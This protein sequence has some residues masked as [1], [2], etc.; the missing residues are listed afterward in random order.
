MS[1]KI[2]STK[3]P[4]KAEEEATKADVKVE[5]KSEVKEGGKK[6]KKETIEEV[7]DDETS[8]VTT[9][10]PAAKKTAVASDEATET[11]PKKKSNPKKESAESKPSKKGQKQQIQDLVCNFINNLPDLLKQFE[12][13][14]QEIRSICDKTKNKKFS[15][16]K[17]EKIP[18]KRQC[19]SALHP[20]IKKYAKEYGL[21][22]ET[23]YDSFAIVGKIKKYICNPEDKHYII[24]SGAAGNKTS[25]ILNSEVDI[26]GSPVLK[27]TFGALIE[28][29]KSSDD[30]TYRNAANQCKLSNI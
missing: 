2:K 10:P 20:V 19:V 11:K 12:E 28:L 16:I 18:N 3:N 27:G 23:E 14:V 25:L 15:N 21:D 26:E 1:V 6:P 30:A 22:P 17:C 13:K 5:A 24:A 7:S 8:G 29:M 9:A 4:I